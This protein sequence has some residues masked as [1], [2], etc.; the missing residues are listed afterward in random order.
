[1]IAVWIL[2]VF[3]P[4]YLTHSQSDN[5]YYATKLQCEQSRER[6]ESVN[7]RKMGYTWH[8]AQVYITQENDSKRKN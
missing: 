1:M 2:I 6:I 3:N 8:C 7:T 4:L 5:F